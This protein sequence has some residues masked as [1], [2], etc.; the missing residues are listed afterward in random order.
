MTKAKY[1]HIGVVL[2]RSGSMSA[3][4]GAMEEAFNSFIEE[5]KKSVTTDQ[6]VKLTFVQFDD[7]IDVLYENMLLDNIK[8]L[9][10]APRGWTALYDAIGFTVDKLG[11]QFANLPESERPEKVLIIVITDG[12][13]NASKM[14]TQNKIFE[15]ITEQRDKYKWEFLFLG[16]N[17]DSVSVASKIGFNATNAYNFSADVQSTSKMS[18][19]LSRGVTHYLSTNSTQFDNLLSIE[20]NDLVTKTK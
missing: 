17:I 14:W 8:P 18:K 6:D 13:E 1:T 11:K 2:D 3:M 10:I 7:K 9:M 20:S 5:Q 19:S 12:E 15:V 16:A 4:K